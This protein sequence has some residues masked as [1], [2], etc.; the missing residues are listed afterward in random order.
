[1]KSKSGVDLGD[2]DTMFISKN[3]S[4]L[5]LLERKRSG[6]ANFSSS[7]KLINQVLA[8]KKNFLDPETVFSVS[9]D[10]GDLSAIDVIS[11]VYCKAGPDSLFRELWAHGIFVVTDSVELFHPSPSE[12]PGD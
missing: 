10:W 11:F 6:S 2:I 3:R 9:A 7:T 4:Q 5:V 8:T 1:M 12:K